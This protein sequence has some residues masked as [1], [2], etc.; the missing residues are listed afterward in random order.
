MHTHV[1]YTATDSCRSCPHRRHAVYTYSMAVPLYISAVCAYTRLPYPAYVCCSC[2]H[3]RHALYTYSMA[4]LLYISIVC[5]YTRMPYRDRLMSLVS[6]TEVHLVHV[7][8]DCTIVHIHCMC[9]HTYAIPRHDYV[10]SVLNRGTLCTRTAGL[11]CGTF[12]THAHTHV[13][14]KIPRALTR[15]TTVQ[16]STPTVGHR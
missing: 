10:A 5:A 14:T 9:I 2:P 11:Y 8:H 1:C 3:R 6:S 15:G 16:V 7:R 13:S 4:V 12:P